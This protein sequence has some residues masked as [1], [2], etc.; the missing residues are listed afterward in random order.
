MILCMTPWF[1]LQLRLNGLLGRRDIIEKTFNQ[2]RQNTSVPVTVVPRRKKFFRQ[3]GFYVFG[4][5]R[6][7]CNH[8]ILQHISFLRS[9]CFTKQAKHYVGDS[10]V[11]RRFPHTFAS[12]RSYGKAKDKYEYARKA[13]ENEKDEIEKS[14]RC[15]SDVWIPFYR[16][17]PQLYEFALER[18]ITRG[19]YTIICGLTESQVLVAFVKTNIFQ[20]TDDGEFVLQFD[21]TKGAVAETLQDKMKWY[22]WF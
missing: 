21:V 2:V 7:C 9:L 13:F 20:P 15:C 10:K 3:R 14:L 19:D 18:P 17:V 12:R 4:F 1:L 16:P 11:M 5:F 6:S 22:C 8:E